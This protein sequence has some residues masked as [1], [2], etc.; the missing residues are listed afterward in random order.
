[1]NFGQAIEL[2]KQGKKVTRKGW[3]GKGMWLKLQIPDADS[4]MTQP[5]V[6][7]E[8]PKNPEHHMY[9]NGSRTPWQASQGDMLAEDWE[10]V[11]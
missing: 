5:Y 3:N 4:L 8:Y 2:L 11:K 10:E 7:I 9:P 1:M 6:Y